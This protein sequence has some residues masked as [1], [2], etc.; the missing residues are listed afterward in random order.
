MARDENFDRAQS[1]WDNLEPE[2]LL[3]EEETEEEVDDV[4]PSEA[5]A[6]DDLSSRRGA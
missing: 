3:P 5:D 6:W 2:D 4:D 1:L